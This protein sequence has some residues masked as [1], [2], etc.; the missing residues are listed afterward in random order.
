MLEAWLRLRMRRR[1]FLKPAV[2]CRVPA[3][4]VSLFV[5]LALW[6]EGMS[7]DANQP[8][9][10]SSEFIFEAGRAPFAQCHASTLVETSN[11][12]VAAWFGGTA[13]RNPNVGIWLTDQQH[14]HWAAPKEVANGKQTEGAR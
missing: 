2:L 9:I 13:E 5:S 1:A 14:G 3:F 10:G 6:R 11:H 8:G 7:Q 12:L 4:W